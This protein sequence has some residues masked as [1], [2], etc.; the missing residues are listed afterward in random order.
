MFSL[1]G[2]LG[3]S[4]RRG[5]GRKNAALAYQSTKFP[6]SASCSS[7]TRT[8]FRLETSCC[9][10]QGQPSVFSCSLIRHCRLPS[11]SRVE[12]LLPAFPYSL[13]CRQR[14]LTSHGFNART[15]LSVLE[16]G[17]K[18]AKS[19]SRTALDAPQP[20]RNASMRTATLLLPH[21]SARTRKRFNLH[22]APTTIATHA[23]TARG[24][25]HPVE[26]RASGAA[27]C[28]PPS[29]PDTATHVQRGQHLAGSPVWAA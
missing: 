20:T 17:W 3:V 26:M 27:S 12:P 8:P 11:I 1:I 21:P 24:N 10:L 14:S 6:A 13:P 7:D 5:D 25:G 18:S 9:S 29:P 28:P 23:T 16:S 19:D 15:F 22:F 2:S 4:R